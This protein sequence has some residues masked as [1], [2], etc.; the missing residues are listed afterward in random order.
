[1][2]RRQRGRAIAAGMWQLP[3][4][5]TA[6]HRAALAG[7]C[8]LAALL[9]QWALDRRV[10]LGVAAGVSVAAGLAMGAVA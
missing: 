8:L 2:A 1:M 5:R 3:Q 6:I 9:A 4:T 7:A 10:A